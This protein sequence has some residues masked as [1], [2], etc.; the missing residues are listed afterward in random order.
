MTENNE[1]MLTPL[2]RAYLEAN[3]EA[4][5]A[6]DAPENF[7]EAQ[8]LSGVGG[9]LLFLII[10][11]IFFGPLLT[12]ALN[13]SELSITDE[14]NASPLSSEE[15]QYFVWLSWA[16]VA[17]YCI[18][19]AAAGLLLLKRHKPSTIPIVIAVIWII[20]PILAFAGVAVEGGLLGGEG[21]SLILAIIWTAYL[22]RSKRVKNTYA[23]SPVEV[24]R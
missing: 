24:F 13:Y 17:A 18:V 15:W 3:P 11:L 6:S 9:W 5:L 7:E 16:M 1:P 19:S 4:T 8:A 2:Q 22:L 10:S 21:R 12:I 14:N 23:D 20:G